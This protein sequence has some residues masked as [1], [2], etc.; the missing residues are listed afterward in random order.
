[1]FLEV[2]LILISIDQKYYATYLSTVGPTSSVHNFFFLFRLQQD[3]WEIDNN[4]VSKEKILKIARER[5]KGWRST[6]SATYKAYDNYDERM[7]NKPQ[8]LDIVEWHYLIMYFGS[9]KFKV[10][11]RIL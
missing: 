5:Y 11:C 8:D 1:M 9:K 4:E 3:L 6:F 7:K 2:C 10:I